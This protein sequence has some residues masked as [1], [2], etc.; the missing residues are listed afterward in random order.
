MAFVDG[1][2]VSTWTERVD[3]QSAWADIAR[4]FDRERERQ[5]LPPP[6]PPVP[7][8]ERVLAWL[9]DV[10]GGRDALLALSPQRSLED[11]PRP[12]EV[13]HSPG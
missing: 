8:Y 2:L 7:T 10:C 3:R 6:P 5:V 1:R 9:D 12:P 4:R 13:R 11:E